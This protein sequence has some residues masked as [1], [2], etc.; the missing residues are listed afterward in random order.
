MAKKIKKECYGT[1]IHTKGFVVEVKDE[2]I[3]M[4]NILGIE[5]VFEP[6]EKKVKFKGIKEDD[7][8][9]SEGNNE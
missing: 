8:N 6:T 9:N 2:N 7:S 4:L 1:T 3:E 5:D